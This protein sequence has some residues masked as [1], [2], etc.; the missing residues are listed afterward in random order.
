M[1]FKFKSPKLGS[2]SNYSSFDG[3]GDAYILANIAQ[4]ERPIVIIASSALEAQ[5]LLEEIPFF[6]PGLK[7]HLL[8]LGNTPLR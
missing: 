2:I 8:G 1:K 7:V 4:Q 6:S 3:S 5:R